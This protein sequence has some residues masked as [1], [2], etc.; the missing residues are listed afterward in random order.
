MS[1]RI[2]PK[3]EKLLLEAKAFAR[4]PAVPSV[5]R[6]GAR[7]RRAK[8]NL[9][10]DLEISALGEAVLDAHSSSARRARRVSIRRHF[11]FGGTRRNSRLSYSQILCVVPLVGAGT[12]SD[13][14]RPFRVYNEEG[15]ARREALETF[16]IHIAAIRYVERP[17]FGYDLVEYIDLIHF[18]SVMLI[19]V[20]LLPGKSER[21]CILTAAFRWRNRAYGNKQRQRS[22]GRV[23]R[24]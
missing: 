12:V 20:G 1:F 9:F 7:P 16:E 13:P 3:Y 15:A 19:N 4:V 10:F 8:L 18:P 11:V 17:G 23:E 14:R 22:M 6:I 21:V 5:F 2:N 24:I